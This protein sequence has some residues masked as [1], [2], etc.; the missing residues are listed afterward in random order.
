MN[1][2]LP[3]S[4]AVLITTPIHATNSASI[5]PSMTSTAS[6]ARAT[7]DHPGGVDRMPTTSGPCMR[8]LSRA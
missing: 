4:C 5:A 1:H 8:K 6:A 7:V 3:G 2:V